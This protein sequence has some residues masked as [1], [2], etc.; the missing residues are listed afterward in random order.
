M[1][2]TTTRLADGREL[3]YYD[4][5]GRRVRD[6]VDRRPL[7]P[8]AT[9]SEI[10]RDPAARRQR[11]HRLPPPGPHLP[12]AGRRVPAL[13]LA[14]RRLSEIPAADYEVA[15][16]ENRFPSPRP[17]TS[18]PAARSS[19]S[20]PTTTPP[21]PTSPRTRPAWCSTP[22]PTAPPSCPQLPGVD[23]VF[24]FENRGKEIGVTLGHP[25]GQI[26]GYPFVTPRTA[27]M[28]RSAA[29]AP[30]GAPARNLFDDMLAA[31]L[32]D[33]R[34]DRAGRASTGPPSS[35]TP[36]AGRTRCTSTPT[37][38]CPTCCPRRG[39]AGRVPAGLPGPAAPLRP[40]LR[41]E[42][43]P[44]R[45]TS[46]AWHQAPVRRDAARRE[47]RTAPGAV[48]DPPH[49]G[50]AEVPGRVRIRHGRVHQRRAAGGR[51]AAAAGGASIMSGSTWSPAAPATSA[52]S[53]P[54][55]CWR[56]ATR[57]PCSTTC[58]P[59]SRRACPTG[60][61]FVE[62]RIQDAAEVLD[63]S[64]EAVLHFAAS[65]QVGESVADPAKYWR[66][67]VGGTL[68]L[69]DAMREAGRAHAR[70]LLHRRHLRRAGVRPDHR[71]PRRPRPPTRT[72]P[73]SSP[74]TT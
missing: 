27:L 52:A 51:G 47:L 15:V 31:E 7:E 14:G 62:G 33:G 36:P 49:G 1:K 70:L 13:P 57:S 8:V 29:A 69:L 16:F 5:R 60:A 12:P 34:R 9:P 6:A 48:H 39:G 59:A 22:G 3:I 65:S 66:N 68:E 53:S 73:P 50:Q 74:S 4:A 37:A 55:I 18:G 17:A 32:A 67:N 40:A 11:R 28:L 46:P 61:D 20:P 42:T 21:S 25:H 10:R 63:A 72:A 30:R 45:R 38:G 23:Q 56:R 41:A 19:A 44:R 43:S 64:F 2:K 35:R 24:C 26:Y 54:P 58:P 71:G